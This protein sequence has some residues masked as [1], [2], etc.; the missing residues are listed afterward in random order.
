MGGKQP[1]GL[2]GAF[3]EITVLTNVDDSMK[4]WQEEVFGPVLPIVTFDT[5]EEAINLANDTMYGL[6]GFVFTEDKQ[7]FS[8]VA[9]KLKTGNIAHNT[10][11]YFSPLTPFGGYKKSGNSR[12]Q[13]LPGFH[14]VT[15][16]KVTAEEK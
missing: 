1:K 5:E 15:Q 4:V 2:D 9:T 14:E 13:G 12:S 3:Y 16:I 11:L 7:R 8:R 10:A 6:G